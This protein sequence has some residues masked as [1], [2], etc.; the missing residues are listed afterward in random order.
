MFFVFNHSFQD[1]HPSTPWYYS[2]RSLFLHSYRP[3]VRCIH[4]MALN[5]RHVVTIGGKIYCTSIICLIYTMDACPFVLLKIGDRQC[6]HVTFLF[7]LGY[8][9]SS[10]SYAVPLDF[11]Y[12]LVHRLLVSSGDFIFFLSKR[13]ISLLF[14]SSRKWI[15]GILFCIALVLVDMI[16]TAVIVSKN[17]YD[18]GLLGNLVHDRFVSLLY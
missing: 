1:I 13:N 12:F 3:T 6:K 2:Y 10:C 11:H 9:V 17:N 14:L 8:M 16:T 4:A 15:L 18:H 5:P 7:S